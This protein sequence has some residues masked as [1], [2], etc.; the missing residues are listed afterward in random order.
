MLHLERKISNMTKFR[1]QALKSLGYEWDSPRSS[2]ATEYHNSLQLTAR[3][4]L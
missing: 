3:N 4:H 2:D 1:I